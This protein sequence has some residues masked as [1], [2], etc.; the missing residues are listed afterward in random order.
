MAI[1]KD[2]ISGIMFLLIGTFIVVEAQNYTMGTL[3]RMGP[4]YL[5]TVTGVL[6][7]LCGLALSARTLLSRGECVGGTSLRALVVVPMSIVAFA[8]LLEPAGLIASTLA[9]VLVARL[10]APRP[11][12]WKATLGLASAL[13]L[14]DVW[15]FWYF[16]GLPFRLWP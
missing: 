8:L 5:P 6:L 7:I 13:V 14:A 4:G 2:L 12:G 9:L 11:L 10:G 16:L 15:V 3:V 1:S